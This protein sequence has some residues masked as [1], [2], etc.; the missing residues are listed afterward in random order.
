M[1]YEQIRQ[2]G[3]IRGMYRMR[4]LLDQKKPPEMGTRL[5]YPRYSKQ[6][7]RI[8]SKLR[9]E[10]VISS[11]GTFVESPPNLHMAAMPL[12]VD[13]EQISVLGSRVPYFLFL[14]LVTGPPGR[15]A[16]LAEGFHFSRKA[17]HDALKRM[18]AARLVRRDSTAA[19]PEEGGACAWLEEHLE[20]VR[21]WADI[22]GDASALFGTIPA[23]VGGPYAR[24]LLEYEPGLPVGS[25][26]MD[27]LTYR[28][29]LGLVES[30][31][32]K[33][34]YFKARS[35]RVSVL[36]PGGAQIRL[37]DGVPCLN[38]TGRIGG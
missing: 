21:V 31:V 27:I 24:R 12:R 15:P 13:R 9:E 30:V 7:Y 16:Y 23:C 6:F 25:A 19:A 33:S 10:G 29:L 20:A 1:L 3:T 11:R 36:P 35:C 34:R 14:A 28:P 37:V 17:V 26:D 22:S 8:K 4:H 2:A 18:G 5:G 32:R 38:G